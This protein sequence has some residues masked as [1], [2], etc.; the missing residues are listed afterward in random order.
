MISRRLLLTSILAAT[1]ML[2]SPG[3]NHVRDGIASATGAPT[4]KEFEALRTAIEDAEQRQRDAERI[5]ADLEHLAGEAAQRQAET[6]RQRE[7]LEA[8]YAAMASQLV[9]LAGEARAAMIEMMDQVRRRIDAVGDAQRQQA[10]V[11]ARHQREIAKTVRDIAAMDGAIADAESQFAQ[12]LQE[13]DEALGG[14]AG[15]VDGLASMA[16][17]LG[18]SETAVE[19]A[20]NA[21]AMGLGLTMAGGPTGVYAWWL[22]RKA[23]ARAKIIQATERYDL[24]A[25]ADPALKAQAKATLTPAQAAELERITAPIAKIT[26]QSG[27]ASGAVVSGGVASGGVAA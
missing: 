18:V 25:D 23:E 9:G 19:P 17:V 7:A 27:G 16:R 6:A 8:H 21:I 2:I 10:E 12:K 4:T 13:R 3:C 22:R 20:R 14:V 26:H 5:R 24:L 15:L 1:V 11:L